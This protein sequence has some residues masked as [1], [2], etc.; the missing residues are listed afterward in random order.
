M[1][2]QGLIKDH[3]KSVGSFQIID[4]NPYDYFGGTKILGAY[5]PDFGFE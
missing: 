3:I 2:E 4:G 1:P 5:Y